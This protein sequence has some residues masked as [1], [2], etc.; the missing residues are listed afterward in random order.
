MDVYITDSDNAVTYSVVPTGVDTTTCFR[1]AGAVTPVPLLPANTSGFRYSGATVVKGVKA[2][3]FQYQSTNYGRVSTY[4]LSVDA[5]DGTTPLRYEMLGYDSLLGS[6]FDKYLVDYTT[7]ELGPAAPVN[8]TS[9]Y[10]PPAGM[11]CRD[12]DGAAASNPLA[13]LAGAMLLSPAAEASDCAAGH[14]AASVRCRYEAFA[15]QHGSARGSAGLGRFRRAA[16]FVE[17]RNRASRATSS[18]LRV[19]LNRF[20]DWSDAELLAARG[21]VSRRDL[22]AGDKRRRSVALR[23]ARPS[24]VHPAPPALTA[25]SNPP[26]VNWTARG[27]V[28]PPPDQAI[29]GSCWAHGAAATIAGSV[30]RKTGKLVPH[31]RQEL[32]DCSWA[33]GNGA[34][35]GGFDFLGYEW[36]MTQSVPGLATQAAYGRYLGQDGRCHNASAASGV[37]ETIKGYTKVQQGS[38][39]ALIDALVNVGPISISIDATLADFTFYSSG[40]YDNPKCLNGVDDLDHTVLAAGYGSSEDGVDYW[41]VRNS[42]SEYW[43]DNGYVKIARR[44]NICGVAT[45]PTYV[46]LA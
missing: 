26:S 13:V 37:L 20:A 45:Q 27:A 1:G 46:T 31:S 34:C 16:H 4:T 9:L 35:N 38:E 23:S 14:P 3:Q 22:P 33:Q 30:F 5:A 10:V 44:G 24:A 18:S 43:G 19:A 40:V 15:A 7:A 2:L 6:H 28:L 25:A 41:L 42:W 11:T 8:A 32:M 36:A 17:G 39:P 12:G 21:G 29:C